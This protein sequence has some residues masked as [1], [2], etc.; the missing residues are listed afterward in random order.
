MYHNPWVNSQLRSR[1]ISKISRSLV[2]LAQIS[3]Y[4]EIFEKIHRE[5]SN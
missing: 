2:D 1:E 5:I 3:R 4:R